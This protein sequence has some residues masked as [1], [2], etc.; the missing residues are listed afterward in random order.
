VHHAPIFS[1]HNFLLRTP[2]L[3]QRQPLRE[4][5][6]A[7]KLLPITSQTV[8]VKLRELHGRNLLRPNQIRKL[9]HREKSQLLFRGRALHPRS[10]RK[11]RPH[12]IPKRNGTR[13]K[14]EGRLQRVIKTQRMQTL[15]LLEVPLD[16]GKDLLALFIRELQTR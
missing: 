12:T 7:Q 13:T 9:P 6:H 16:C 15:N 2:S 1:P 14:N 11:K 5:H 10:R 8:K 4:A 3:L